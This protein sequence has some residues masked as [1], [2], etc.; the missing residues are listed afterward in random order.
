MEPRIAARGISYH[1]G[2]KRILHGV[3]LAAR[4]G[5]FVGLLG[6]NGAGKSTLLRVLAGLVKPSMGTV[7]IDGDDLTAMRPIDVARKVAYVPQDTHVAFDFSVWEIV[8]MGRHPHLPRFAVEGKRDHEIAAL[9]MEQVG[10]RHLG[11][12]SITSLSGGERQ[13]VFIAKALAQQPQI[14][15][16]DEPVSAL[17]IRHQLHVLSLVR[18]YTEKG[19]TAIA[20]LH[21]LNLAARFCHRLYLM[22]EGAVTAQGPPDAVYTEEA[23]ARSYR[24]RAAVRYDPLVQSTTVTALGALEERAEPEGLQTTSESHENTR[25]T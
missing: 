11:D 9:A 12:R 24:V 8:L 21:D 5:E 20:V 7:T 23:L 19:A 1:A 18:S 16:L 14:L 2:D 10:V 17:D 22:A 6:P 4:D 13:M 15:L 25:T 3:D